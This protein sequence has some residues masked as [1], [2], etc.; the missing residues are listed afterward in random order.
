[1]NKKLW[2]AGSFFGLTAVIL[3]AF[4]AH[5]LKD[6]IDESAVDSFQT[7]VRYQMYH[8]LLLLV[9]G[10]TSLVP[11]NTKRLVFFG[12]LGG[13][14]LFSGSIYALATDQLTNFDFKTF[15]IVTPIGGL[16]LV[17][18]WLTLFISVLKTKEYN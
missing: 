13:T 6:L 4:A 7:G 10:T 11:E 1:M 15:G 16:I 2:I 8:A 18:S 3:G 17:I 14:L 12:V 5:G 9:I